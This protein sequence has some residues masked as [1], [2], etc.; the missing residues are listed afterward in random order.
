[1]TVL[2]DTC[3]VVDALQKR[4]PFFE[5]AEKILLLCS[6]GQCAGALTAKSLTDIYYLSHKL[7]H[8][9]QLSRLILSKLCTFLSLLDTK[10]A[11]LYQALTSN[12]SDFEDA[13]MI[14]TVKRSKVDCIIT[15]NEK[16][17]RD[18][19][20]PVYDPKSFLDLFKGTDL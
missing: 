4:G 8:N 3:V 10:A 5:D 9:D 7:T 11:D 20:V 15:R 17:Y 1:M 16:D 12:I 18:S 19:P 13:V 2:L 6:G 14:E